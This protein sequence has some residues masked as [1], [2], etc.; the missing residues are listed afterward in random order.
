MVPNRETSKNVVQMWAV[1][2]KK[3]KLGAYALKRVT[4]DAWCLSPESSAF[5]GLVQMWV[6]LGDFKC[7]LYRVGSNVGCTWLEK[8]WVVL[9]W[10][11]C[12]LCKM[13]S[14]VL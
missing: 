12:G 7:G 8:I 3:G 10:F 6:V 2:R 5:T 4:A 1:Q 9:G 11:E 14:N 13:G